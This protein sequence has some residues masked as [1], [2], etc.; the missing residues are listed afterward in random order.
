ME[1]EAFKEAILAELK[2]FYGKDAD[3]IT[4]KNIVGSS[5]GGKQN[6][7]IVISLQKEVGGSGGHTINLSGLYE[8]Y[9]SGRLDL[10]DC[11]E[12]IYRE[13]EGREIRNRENLSDYNVNC[14]VKGGECAE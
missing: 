2:D 4:V 3:A 11:V 6:E 14:N 13:C 9:A 8:Q 7:G 10:Y 1:Y 12:A 5:G